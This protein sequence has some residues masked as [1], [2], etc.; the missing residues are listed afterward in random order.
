ME[1]CLIQFRAVTDPV[2]SPLIGWWAEYYVFYVRH[3]DLQKQAADSSTLQAMMLD[4]AASV[5]AIA[6]NTG[7]GRGTYARWRSRF[8]RVT[9]SVIAFFFFLSLMAWKARI[10]TGKQIGRAHV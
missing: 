1:N 10:V 3:R 4:P 8:I 2:K 6:D 5:A 7:R 9:V